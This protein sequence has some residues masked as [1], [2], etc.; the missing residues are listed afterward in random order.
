MLSVCTRSQQISLFEVTGAPVWVMTSLEI[1]N[2][3]IGFLVRIFCVISSLRWHCKCQGSYWNWNKFLRRV[4]FTKKICLSMWSFNNVP[5]P[6]SFSAVSK[7]D[8]KR[9]SVSASKPT[10]TLS[11][12]KFSFSVES[13][14]FVNCSRSF[15]HSGFIPHSRPYVSVEV[16]RRR[17]G[18][19]CHI[20]NFL[21]TFSW[22]RCMTIY[23]LL[24]NFRQE[25]WDKRKQWTFILQHGYLVSRT[26]F[27]SFNRHI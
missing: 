2:F 12:L 1:P 16:G 23:R 11:H 25:W 10:T 4:C 8:L 20:S 26:I 13:I 3:S 6:F 7:S 21:A 5:P 17:G 14:L 27:E 15:F 9:Q 19:H 24:E 22:D 18:G